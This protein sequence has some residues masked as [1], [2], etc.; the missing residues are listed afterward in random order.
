MKDDKYKNFYNYDDMINKFKDNISYKVLAPTGRA[1]VKM[2]IKW[3]NNI[4][5]QLID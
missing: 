5:Q 2:L 4:L 1:E 3:L